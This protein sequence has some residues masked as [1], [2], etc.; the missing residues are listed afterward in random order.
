M[1]QTSRRLNRKHK[2]TRRITM[3]RQFGMVSQW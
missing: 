3:I 1:A 2:G